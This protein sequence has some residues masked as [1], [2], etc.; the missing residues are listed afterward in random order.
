MVKE[1]HPYQIISVILLIAVI[2]FAGLYFT[3]SVPSQEINEQTCSDFIEDCP[4]IPVEKALI[5]GALNGWFENLYDSSEYVIQADIFNF[6][7]EEAKNVEV[8]CEIYV[9]DED[10]YQVSEYPINTVV[11]KIGNVASTSY[12]LVELTTEKNYQKE[13]KYPLANCLVTACDNCEILTERI[14]EFE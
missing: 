9:G 10:G 12:K 11:K 7:Y 1:N 13:G 4:E 6:G 2:A 3:K 5:Y 14:P 8:T